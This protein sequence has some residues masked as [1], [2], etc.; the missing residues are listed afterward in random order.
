MKKAILRYLL[1]VV[2]T[3]VL[4]YTLYSCAN[5][6]AGPQGGPKDTIPPCILKTLPENASIYYNK[7]K[8]EIL[9]DEIV[10]V[11]KAH[12]K[13]V[14]SPPQKNNAMVKA[15]G[16]KV[17][18]QFNDSILPATTYVVDF[19]DAIVDN[20]EK[21]PLPNYAFT[22][23]SGQFLDT[24]RM[25]GHVIDAATL[26]PCAG[27]LVGAYKNH[28]DTAFTSTPFDIIAKTDE[29]GYFCIKNAQEGEKY[30]IFALKDMNSNYRFDMPEEEIAFVDSVFAPTLWSEERID[31]V[32]RDS[33]T[34]DTI[35]TYRIPKYSPN[36]VVLRLFK[37]YAPTQKYIKAE[38]KLPYK[39][40][41]FFNAPLD[42]L[43]LVRP[44]NFDMHGTLVQRS[45]KSDTLTY[46]LTDSL[47]WRVDTLR[48]ELYHPKT[49]SLGEI[50]ILMDTINL[51]VRAEVKRNTET[52]RGVGGARRGGKSHEEEKNKNKMEY[53]TMN[54]TLKSYFDVYKPIHLTFATPIK[55]FDV[56]K[57]HLEQHRDTLW[58]ERDVEFT[59]DSMRMNFS[60]A[61]DW[62]A[63]SEYRLTLDSAMF[64][65]YYGLHT[66][67]QEMKFRTRSL[68][69]YANLYVFLTH[70]EG[71]EHL[72]LLNKKEEVVREQRAQQETLF[73]YLDPGEYYL[74]LFIDAN[75]NGVWDTGEYA[76]G[77]QPEDTYFYPSKIELRAFWDVE[78]EW[79]YTQHYI[80]QQ[81][82]Q[83]LIKKNKK[84]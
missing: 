35:V 37:E 43:P 59:W 75:D 39:F 55:E 9:F 16:K 79:D 38:R 76:T 23:S 80:L 30:R 20:N 7:Q 50:Q 6:G 82:P 42:T 3:V 36:N 60:I 69:E 24:L 58:V 18:V 47:A 52:T 19:A 51:P 15:Y 49:D 63:E 22:F 33:V 77:L 54:N 67:R 84:R 62:V 70:F 41:L 11:E 12:E 14:V 81:K 17:V 5:R 25:S 27:V 4:A 57:L 71:N 10:L 2:P 64:Y 73:E 45:A 21:N 56:T 8:V 32:M 44:L 53:L 34:I 29:Y 74:K 13:V 61:H 78:E 26:N 72:L 40:S 1:F 48:F 83:E 46:W 65:D 66:N 28:D 31:T 68:E